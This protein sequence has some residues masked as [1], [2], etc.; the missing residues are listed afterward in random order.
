[1]VKAAADKVSVPVVM[2]LDHGD[3]FERV[4]RCLRTGYTSVMIDA[5]KT[6]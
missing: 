6:I 2:H 5:S 1:M 4:A 3:D